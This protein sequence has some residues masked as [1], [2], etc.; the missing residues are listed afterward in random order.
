[1]ATGSTTLQATMT[2]DANVAPPG[3]YMLSVTNDAGVPSI[4]RWVRVGP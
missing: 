2:S 1:M 3:R 4:A